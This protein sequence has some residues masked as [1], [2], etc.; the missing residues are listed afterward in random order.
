MDPVC[1][2]LVGLALAEAGLKHRAPAATATLMLGANL[3]DVDVAS[4]AWGS[5]AALSFRRGWT[6]GVPALVVLP[7]VLATLVF[8]ALRWRGL[9]RGETLERT[10][11]AQLT[12][13]SYVSVLTHPLL[14]ALNT[15][16]MRWLM[17]FANRWFYADTLFIVDPW[18]WGCLAA[19]AWMARKRRSGRPARVALAMVMAYIVAMW[20]G[21]TVVRHQA[22]A[23][24]ETALG[25]PA[26]GVLVSPVPMIPWERLVV[27]DDG[28]RYR[29]GR[30]R[31]F[32]RPGFALGDY[33]VQ[34]NH[35]HPAALVAAATPDGAAFLRW[36]R[37]P[38]FVVVGHRGGTTVHIVDARYTVDPA[39]GFGAFTIELATGVGLNTEGGRRREAGAARPSL[40]RRGG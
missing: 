24:T 21:T 4:Y 17:P 27:V 19:G 25:H 40:G 34:K 18:V 36:A 1:H 14:D 35:R 13:L 20:T 5:L 31:W 9:R 6:H 12:F 26:A 37:L 38:F 10:A 30:H 32:R 23:A 28:E 2:T 3:P 8:G 15:Y 29:F 39:G 22:R 16:G 33:A 11:F 7:L